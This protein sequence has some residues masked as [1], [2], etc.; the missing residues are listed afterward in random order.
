MRE[1]KRRRRRGKINHLVTNLLS[2]QQKSSHS[3]IFELKLISV[4]CP[5][6]FSIKINILKPNI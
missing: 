4:V 1:R 3:V 5:N 6:L 2:Q